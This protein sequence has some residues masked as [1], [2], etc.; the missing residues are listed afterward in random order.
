MAWVLSDLRNRKA[1]AISFVGSECILMIASEL[2]S[3]HWFVP[4]ARVLHSYGQYVAAKPL[5]ELSLGE[6]G[7]DIAACALL[8]S[9]IYVLWKWRED[10]PFTVA[11]CVATFSLLI[12][13]HFYDEILLL[14]PITWLALNRIRTKLWTSKILSASVTISLVMGWF[15]MI[16]ISLLY[17]V[18]QR[19]A[20]IL[21]EF[22]LG[23]AGSLPFLVFF[24]L[25]HQAF[26]IRSR[27]FMRFSL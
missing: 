11:Y 8:F 21:W 6:L 24:A 14:A 23:L 5:V 15:F 12:R 7:G 18:S 1:V 26:I 20:L 16:A 17:L 25:W 2:F 9:L 10:L 4:W 13:F 3:P 27:I 22:P 19:V